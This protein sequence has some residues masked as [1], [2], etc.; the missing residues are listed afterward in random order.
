MG[1]KI[2]GFI[3]R[4]FYGVILKLSRNLTEY[5]AICDICNKKVD[6]SDYGYMCKKHGDIIYETNL[7]ILPKFILR[8]LLKRKKKW[9][10]E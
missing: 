7:K 9:N 2:R 5:P 1:K 4:N 8:Y 10:T 6:F 3:C